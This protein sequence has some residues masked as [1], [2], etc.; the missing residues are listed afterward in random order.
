MPNDPLKLKNNISKKCK[1]KTTKHVVV[2]KKISAPPKRYGDGLDRVGMLLQQNLAGTVGGN[3]LAGL[4]VGVLKE[5]AFDAELESMTLASGPAAAAAGTEQTDEAA[6]SACCS[7]S[8]D[9]SGEGAGQ[10]AALG[11][12]SKMEEDDEQR[13]IQQGGK[14]EVPGSQQQGKGPAH[15][16]VRGIVQGFLAQAVEGAARQA[17]ARV[18]SSGDPVEKSWKAHSRRC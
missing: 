13:S 5:K 4:F 10:G 14:G 8:N 2:K 1:S 9:E 18:A 16:M 3:H 6:S 17:E 11:A 15:F 12:D 7:A